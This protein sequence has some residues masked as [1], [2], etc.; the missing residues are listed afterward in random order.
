MVGLDSKKMAAVL[1]SKTKRAE[2]MCA[3]GP[4]SGRT[5]AVIAAQCQTSIEHCRCTQNVPLKC[6]ECWRGV[7]LFVVPVRSTNQCF[8]L[9]RL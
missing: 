9:Q 7:V 4:R 5:R 2:V 3:C 1:Y 8:L 6:G